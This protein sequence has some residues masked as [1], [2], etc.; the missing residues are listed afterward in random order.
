M[1]PAPRRTSTPGTDAFNLGNAK[2]LEGFTKRT[3]LT[4][5]DNYLAAGGK[6]GVCNFPDTYATTAAYGHRLVA[7]RDEAW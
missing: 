3:N 6:N 5:K 4:F 7:L 2:F 1:A